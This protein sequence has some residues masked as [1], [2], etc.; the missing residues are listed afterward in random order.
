M[1]NLLIMGIDTRPMVSSALKLD[2]K[3]ISIS[4]FKDLDFPE[5]F[6]ERHVFNPEQ[7]NSYG[8]FEESYS[9]Q[10]LLN[11][12]NEFDIDLIDK[13][14]LTTGI[15]AEDFKGDFS[16]LKSRIRGNLKT[17]D[18]SDKFK[19]YEKARNKFNVP[20]TFRLGDVGELKEIIK[21]YDNNS[22]ILKP[23]NGSGGLGFLKLNNDSSNQLNNIENEIENISLEN[24]MLQEYVEGENVSSSVLSTKDEAR[25]LVNTRLITANDLY[26]SGDFSYVGNIVPLDEK[27]FNALNSEYSNKELESSP[28]SK[29]YNK[30]DIE[31]SNYKKEN[32]RLNSKKYTEEEIN[33]LNKEMKEVSEDLIKEFKLIGSNGVDFKIDTQ[34]NDLKIIEVNPRLQGTYQLCENAL[35]INMLEAHIKACEGELIEIPN[36]KQYSIKK[37]IYAPKEVKIENLK[38]KNLYDIPHPGEIIEKGN[39]IATIICSNKDLNAA[40]NDLKTANQKVNQ[41]LKI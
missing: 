40:M 3:T 17:S 29:K 37:I 38:I 36:P 35:G 33:A 23:L 39:P 24:Y 27:S 16:K 32:S 11:L 41:T 31:S 14:V 8:S 2:Y 15:S 4:Y 6:A 5:P 21:Q 9:P 18:V 25:N 30:N 12:L 7:D 1:E 20:L 13:V 34:K 28:H 22:F 19:F 10:S 26:S